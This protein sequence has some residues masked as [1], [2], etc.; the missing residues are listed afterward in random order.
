MP[1]LTPALPG[2][3]MHGCIEN[4]GILE[5]WRFLLGDRVSQ[6]LPKSVSY[7][8]HSQATKW[9]LVLQV[10]SLRLKACVV[11]WLVRIMGLGLGLMILYDPQL[12]TN[13]FY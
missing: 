5:F 10:E 8:Y 13:W 7:S 12:L 4:R 3:V 11:G 9:V 1:C 2:L 6:I